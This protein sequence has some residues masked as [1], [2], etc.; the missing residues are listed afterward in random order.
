MKNL[1]YSAVLFSLINISFASYWT[2]TSG[3]NLWNTAQ[4]W[5]YGSGSVPTSVDEVWIDGGFGKCVIGSGV[6]A[7]SGFLYVNPAGSGV[8]APGLLEI[9]GGTFNPEKLIIGDIASMTG[10]AKV[11]F[12]GGTINYGERYL[13]IADD[14]TSKGW[15][16]ISGNAYFVMNKRTN[17]GQNGEGKLTLTGD[18]H[19]KTNGVVYVANKAGAQGYLSVD[20]NAWM[21]LAGTAPL[22]IGIAAQGLVELFGG[23]ITAPGLEMGPLSQAALNVAGGELIIT[24]DSQ[25]ALQAWIDAGAI[26]TT[27][28]NHTVR[29]RYDSAADSTT[30][31]TEQNPLKA[32]QPTPGNGWKRVPVDAAL[33][34]QPGAMALS[35]DVFL[36][37]DEGLVTTAQKTPGDFDGDT[38]V[39]I[40]DFAYLSERWFLAATGIHPFPDISGDN[41]VDESDAAVMAQNW[42]APGDPQFKA[43]T[44]STQYTPQTLQPGQKYYWRVDQ[45]NS[46]QNWQG[47][48]WSFEVTARDPRQA[49]QPVPHDFG[50]G[51]GTAN[52]SLKWQ[53]GLNA[54]LHD[55]Y[56]GTDYNA[57]ANATKTS[58]EYITTQSGTTY[59]LGG[60]TPRQT[61]YWRIDEFDGLQTHKGRIWSFTATV[62]GL[63]YGIKPPENVYAIPF[64]GMDWDELITLTSLQGI[65]AQD[66]PQ[67]YF[68]KD[69]VNMIWLSNLKSEYNIDTAYVNTI[70][71]SQRYIEWAID[72]FYSHINGYIRYDSASNPDSLNIASS[73]AGLYKAVIVDADFESTVQPLLAAKGLSM[74]MDV[75]TRDN[76]WLYNN[77]FSQMNNKLIIVK[78]PDP[79]SWY[80]TRLHDLS[81]AAK[82]LVLWDDDTSFTGTVFDSIVSNSP[83]FGWS[84]AAYS[85]EGDF[86]D[87]HANHNLITNPSNGLLNLS[88]Y[89][90]MANIE[91]RIKFQQKVR[92]STYTPETGV[93][94]ATFIQS[95]LD[96]ITF[97]I[98][99]WA[100]DPERYANPARGQVP[101]G[102]AMAMPMLKMA[103]HVMKWWYDNAAPNES[104]I[105]P[106]S[107]MG[108][109]HPSEFP[110]L[111]R[112]VEQLG[113]YMTE[114]DIKYVLIAEENNFYYQ[115]SIMDSYANIPS[116]DGFFVAGGPYHEYGDRISWRN[117]KPFVS[118]RYSM[119]NGYESISSLISKFNSSSLNVNDEA[120]YS[121]VVVHAWSTDPQGDH[122]GVD[123]IKYI[124]DHVNSNVRIVHPEE[125]M[126]HVIH[127]HAD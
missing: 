125:F 24:G 88:F 64:Q 109:I 83:C 25:T 21:E 120:A 16:D 63:D 98:G 105:V 54:V 41:F 10:Y 27:L 113:R 33:Q 28:P 112:H 66:R 72:N 55:I 114:A 73:L 29:A 77:Y 37:T 14:A 2:N 32:T 35:H 111:D 48:V 68:Y 78:D 7:S 121:A 34:W 75:S 51:H 67:L 106:F 81:A 65:V 94:Y 102:W 20:D 40:S 60:L 107:G 119:W 11:E 71:G 57:V 95:D 127:N 12:S 61:Y 18:A 117:G 52:Q 103:P 46:S 47:D 38:K 44:I 15:F 53:P 124:A 31:Y 89:M 45:V 56:F 19:F 97:T 108:Y 93:H 1:F 110:A 91:P 3:N 59:N 23:K 115:Y 92:G 69:G 58:A 9:T 104:F 62:Y 70:I 79:A 85:N 17:I 26:Y 6:L 80:C 8:T 96:N 39:N 122:Y 86:V 49:Q 76:Q 13:I 82:C 22:Q 84:D 5:D 87:Y 36:G 100:T 50:E 101:Y 43:A 116:A 99:G 4:N 74:L 126:F 30:L 118:I 90:G 123:D 42:L